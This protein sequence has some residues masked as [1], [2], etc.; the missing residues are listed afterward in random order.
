MTDLFGG[1]QIDTFKL[2]EDKSLVNP[3]SE[4]SHGVE[5]WDADEDVDEDLLAYRAH[6]QDYYMTKL[7]L[8][9]RGEKK[10]KPSEAGE[11][12]ELLAATL[13]PICRSY[14][15]TL[16]W[17]LEY[18]FTSV[19][20]WNEY[21]PYHYAPFASDLLIFTRRFKKDGPDNALQQDLKWADFEK[22]TKPLLPFEQ[23]MFIMPPS[24][25]EI[26]PQPYRWLLA[27]EGT[28]VSDFFPDDFRTD[29]NGKLASW[30]AVI[31]IP[32]IDR[33]QMF[34]AM[35]PCT[36]LLSPEDA[37]RNHH[38]GHLIL[39]A[40]EK[41]RGQAG[42]TFSELLTA[43]VD[44]KF[45]RDNL[46]RE[47]NSCVRVYCQFKRSVVASFPN[48]KRLPYTSQLKRIGV[49][50]YPLFKLYNNFFF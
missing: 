38:S 31:L 35:A 13:L 45:Y 8:D 26:L 48:L 42:A 40:N 44:G 33:T 22:D 43:E 50:V 3:K 18:Y 20:D 2:K 7:N 41:K 21:Y 46:L 47:F 4:I 36:S 10:L 49:Q 34:A 15:K 1:L 30:E 14:I 29:I 32:F 5:V 23:Q 39:K 25:A 28:P 16:Q 37:A 12:S 6:R 24:S 9:I 11:D 17:I 27:T 19:I